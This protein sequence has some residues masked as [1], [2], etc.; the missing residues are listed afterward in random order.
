[1]LKNKNLLYYLVAAGLFMLM[2]WIYTFTHT[3]H[4]IFL[5][6]PAEMFVGLL[7]GSHSIYLDGIGYYFQVPNIIID[8][9]CAGFNFWAISFL[10]FSGL[11]IKYSDK[12]FPVIFSFLIAITGTY[13]LTIFVNTSRI[14]TS[15]IVQGFTTTFFARNQLTIHEIIG[16]INNLF[17]L[18]LFYYLAEKYLKHKSPDAKTV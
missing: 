2:K 7:T 13:L 18:V 5:I 4:L 12:S 6:K 17:F 1:M 9:S 11:L 16:I 3:E 15:V 14:F 10:I 8:K